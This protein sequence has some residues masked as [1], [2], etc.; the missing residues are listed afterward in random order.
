MTDGE[1]KAADGPA[2]W[3][4]AREAAINSLLEYLPGTDAMDLA[5]YLEGRGDEAVRARVEAALVASPEALE[6][7]VAARQALDAGSAAAPES[8]IARAQDLVPDSPARRPGWMAWLGRLPALPW[9]PQRAM[10]LATV[11]AGFIVVSV[12]GFELGRAEYDYSSQVDSLLAREVGSL[13]DG[14]GE[15]LL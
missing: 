8:L 1:K 12:A 7:V 6:L 4:H 14:G 3:A 5:A 9:A 11:A 15:D 10:A 13:L 2:L